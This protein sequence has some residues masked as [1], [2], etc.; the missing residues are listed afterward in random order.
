MKHSFL[1]NKT[2]HEWKKAFISEDELRKIANLGQNEK[3]YL[4]TQGDDELITAQN[5]VDLAREG[6]EQIYSV[7][8]EK[9]QF[10]VN[11]KLFASHEA[12]IS[13]AELRVV[14]KI[15]EEDNIFL[16]VEGPD[17]EILK[18][19]LI[20]LKPYPIEEFYS[21]SVKLVHITINRKPYEIKPGKYSVAELKKIGG[22]N[23]GHDLD[24]LVGH[25]LIP[26]DDNGV[27]LIKGCEE[28]KSHPKDGQSS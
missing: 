25:E 15:P 8:K 19:Q 7:K 11:Q 28:F 1:F 16:K 18:G 27:L 6:I 23:P 10:I 22:V 3:I 13:E 12:F 9:Y 26:L 17:R 2:Y 20:D 5:P 24:Q 14:G 4:K 21:I